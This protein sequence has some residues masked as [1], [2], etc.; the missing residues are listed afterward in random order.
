MSKQY[1]KNKKRN[2]SNN[3]PSIKSIQPLNSNQALFFD[4]FNDYDCHLLTG[5]AGVGKSFIALYKAL[6]A[7]ENKEYRHISI[8]RSNEVTGKDLGALPGTADEKMAPFELPYTAM[9]N[10][11]YGRGDMYGILKK[12]GVLSF[13]SP[14][15]ARGTTL[16][17][18]VVIIDEFQN[19]TAHALDTLITRSGQNTKLVICGDMHQQDLKRKSDKDVVKALN[20]LQNMDSTNT[21]E[22]SMSDIVRSGFVK[23][24]IITKN[25]H[26]SQGY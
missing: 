18:T 15:F 19:L 1:K 17:N 12:T 2:R 3:K 7:Y 4:T 6:E 16:D 24:Y 5:W 21:I 22:F 25:K 14:S 9:V 20:V 10:D 26:Y 23:E 11:I 8:Y 13:E